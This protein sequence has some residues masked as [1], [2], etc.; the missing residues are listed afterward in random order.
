ME[1]FAQFYHSALSVKILKVK[2]KQ[3]P[4]DELIPPAD[5]YIITLALLSL[6]IIYPY[7]N[8]TAIDAFFFG[9]SGSTESGL[10]TLVARVSGIGNTDSA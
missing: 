3:R 6:A 7:G 10:N 1:A 9:A 2:L 8:L 4:I 5:A